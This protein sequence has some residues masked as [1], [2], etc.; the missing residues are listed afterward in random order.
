RIRYWSFNLDNQRLD[1]FGASVIS[2]RHR[3]LCHLGLM[4]YYF[5]RRRGG[6]RNH[7][8]FVY[9]STL[10][11]DTFKSSFGLVMLL[12]GRVLKPKDEADNHCKNEDHY[13]FHS[14]EQLLLL[15]EEEVIELDDSLHWAETKGVIG[16][17]IHFDTLGDMQELFKMLVSIV[18]RKSIKLARFLNLLNHVILKSKVRCMNTNRGNWSTPTIQSWLAQLLHSPEV[19]N[20]WITVSVSGYF[21]IIQESRI[22][23][24]SSSKWVL[25]PPPQATIALPAILPLSPVLSLPPMFDSQDFFSYEKIS[26]PK[27]TETPV[28][29]SIPVSP[30]SSVGSSSPVR[31]TT[32]PPDYPFDKSIFPELDNS[33]WI[34]PRPLGSKPVLE[35]PNESDARLWK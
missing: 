7:G 29:S 27:D 17:P 34:I 25:H 1:V 30:S 5:R 15:V 35:E 13:K 21:K 12:L 20:W 3:V 22:N 33:L 16:D 19:E 32:S 10:S 28:K 23:M 24:R 26:P 18:T 2:R 8:S 14:Y 6:S 31:S 4:F 11:G 9:I